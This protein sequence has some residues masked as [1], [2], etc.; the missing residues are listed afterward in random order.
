[1]TT[2]IP[3]QNYFFDFDTVIEECVIYL[4]D[5]ANAPLIHAQFL[6]ACRSY[7]KAEIL[8]R[9]YADYPCYFKEPFK[10]LCAEPADDLSKG[11]F[12]FDGAL[13]ILEQMLEA[14]ISADSDSFTLEGS[15]IN[16]SHIFFDKILEIAVTSGIFPEKQFVV[17]GNEYEGD[18]HWVTIYECH[19]GKMKSV[20]C[21]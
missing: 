19:D 1:M 14:H 5:D 21:T 11:I 16:D 18:E 8:S 3:E 12:D 2:L 4:P 15:A 17:Q 20:Y 13:V 9:D 6:D 10:H 7:F